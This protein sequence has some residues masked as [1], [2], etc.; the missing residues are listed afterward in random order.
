M[1]P[2]SWST[3]ALGLVGMVLARPPCA[4]AQDLAAYAVPKNRVFVAGIS[5]GGYMAV[6]MHVAYSGLFKGAAIYAG[7]PNYCAQDSLALALTTCLANAPPVNAAALVATTRSW[8]QQGLIDPVGNLQG[9]PVYLWSG[10]LDTTVRQPLMDALQAYYQALG[11]NVFQYDRD[12]FAEHG[13]ESPYGPQPCGTAASPYVI[14]CFRGYQQ[15]N[16]TGS[17]GPGYGTAYDSEQVWLTRWLGRLN[18]KNEGA[19]RGAVVPFD[20]NRFAPGGNAAA[21]SMDATG[22]AFVP[23]DCAAGRAC[24]L[25]LA[26]H[27]CQ[28]SHGAVGMAF[29]NDAG[30]NQWADT[31]H[32]VVLYPQAIATGSTGSNPQGCWD[33]WGYLNDPDYALR[34]GPQMQTLYRMVVRATSGAAKP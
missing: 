4:H 30:L 29:V 21:I 3:L 14:T 13:W 32:L 23:A 12:F 11:A 34:S 8:A 19:L 33:W 15:Q 5:S 2:K 18:P 31:N 20:Q 9:Q 16:G 25:V 22:Y 17:S 6:Q 1:R 27:G 7:G 28:Q 26:L 24:G 10:L